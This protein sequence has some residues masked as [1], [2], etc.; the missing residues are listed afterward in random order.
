[1]IVAV[2][3]SQDFTREGVVRRQRSTHS[4]RKYSRVLWAGPS[5]LRRTARTNETTERTI[6]S[7][8][9]RTNERTNDPSNERT[10]R[11]LVRSE[12]EKSNKQ[13]KVENSQNSLFAERRHFVILS[14]C[15]VV[16]L[17]ICHFVILSFLNA[18]Y[19]YTQGARDSERWQSGA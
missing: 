17:P 15:D 1:M 16:V 11:C 13:S 2:G 4:L 3:R 19:L 14:L 6:D 12:V 10:L 9:E 18:V 7:L 8:N 5:N